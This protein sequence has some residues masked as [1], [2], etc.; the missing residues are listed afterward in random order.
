MTVTNGEIT[1][2]NHD[3]LFGDVYFADGQSIMER[4]LLQ[5]AHSF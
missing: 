3:I 4:Q 1:V 5:T 2:A